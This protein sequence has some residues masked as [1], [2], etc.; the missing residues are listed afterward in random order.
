MS[1]GKGCL[2]I[3]GNVIVD[4]SAVIVSATVPSKRI[5]KLSLAHI[6]QVFVHQVLTLKVSSSSLEHLLLVI[7]EDPCSIHLWFMKR[8]HLVVKNGLVVVMKGRNMVRVNG[9]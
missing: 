4:C 2:R 9:D 1:T 7:K 3:V 6:T 5:T 8:R